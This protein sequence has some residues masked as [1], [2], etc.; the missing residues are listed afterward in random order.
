MKS[1][2]NISDIN[3]IKEMYA[4]GMTAEEISAQMQIHLKCVESFEPDVEEDEDDEDE[5]LL[6]E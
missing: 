5:N 6:G 1:G 3:R 4:E 2:A